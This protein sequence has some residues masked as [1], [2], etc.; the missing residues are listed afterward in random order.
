MGGEDIKTGEGVEDSKPTERELEL[1]RRLEALETKGESSELL[2]SLLQDEDVQ[3]I[4][5]MKK[6]GK[7][8]NVMEEDDESDVDPFLSL[9]DKKD[10][11]FD[12]DLLSNSQLLDHFVKTS[13]GALEALVSQKVQEVLG[14]VKSLRDSIEDERVSRKSEEHKKEFLELNEKHGEVIKSKR[15]DLLKTYDEYLGK[16][17]ALSPKEVLALTV[18]RDALEG[19]LPRTTESERPS[20]LMPR[21]APVHEGN[22]RQG[23]RGWDAMLRESLSRRH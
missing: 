2:T 21:E 9:R 18:G 8:V 22:V 4:I 16:G 11:E 14:E 12:V 6:E 20:T 13:A 19:K 17:V 15:E 5:N 23:P 7:K 10:D 1:Q 3:K